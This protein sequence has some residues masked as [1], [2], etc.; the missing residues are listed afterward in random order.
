MSTPN[1]IRRWRNRC[2]AWVEKTYG[3]AS[4]EDLRNRGARIA[5]EGVEL[6]QCEGVPLEQMRAIV[7]RCYS[8]P[9]GDPKQETA[10]VFF[11]L[12]VYVH[13]KKFDLLRIL[14]TEVERVERKDPE[15][16]RAKQREK[17]AAGTDLVLPI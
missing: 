7:E 5:E 17:F 3:Q 10:G 2:S 6:A 1:P 14:R 15:V 11:T 9:A 16:F 12:L 13:Q 8:R 4:L